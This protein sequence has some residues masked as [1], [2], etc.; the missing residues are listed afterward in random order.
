MSLDIL[1]KSEI[2]IIFAAFPWTFPTPTALSKYTT[3]YIQYGGK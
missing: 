1:H 2:K 3:S